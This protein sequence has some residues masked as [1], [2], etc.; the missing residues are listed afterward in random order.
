MF[1]SLGL[2]KLKMYNWHVSIDQKSR[3][4]SCRMVGWVGWGPVLWVQLL[5]SPM[6]RSDSWWPQTTNLNHQALGWEWGSHHPSRSQAI[7]GVWFK[8]SMPLA[9][10]HTTREHAG[11]FPKILIIKSYCSSWVSGFFAPWYLKSIESTMA[12]TSLLILIRMGNLGGIHHDLTRTCDH[13]D[14]L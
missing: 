6:E 4:S 8:G 12:K 1:T 2:V 9:E 5:K 14:S 11:R 3:L 13:S 10:H 7:W